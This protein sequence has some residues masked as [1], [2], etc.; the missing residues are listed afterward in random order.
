MS[1]PVFHV[2]VRQ[3]PNAARAFNLSR[4]ELEERFAQPWR[5]GRS[6]ELDDRRWNP[7]KAR[8]AVYEGRP[9][10]PEEIGMGRGWA[11]A[12]R[13]GRDVTEEILAEPS[14]VDRFKTE[15]P[16]RATLADLVALAAERYP[17][18]RVSERVA[19]AEEA[20]WQLLHSGQGR[21]IRGGRVL[22]RD[23]WAGVLLSWNAWTDS[24][25]WLDSTPP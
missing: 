17:G 14:A 11:N 23:E 19:L 8:L 13:T 18:S 10:A 24:D 9:L 6:V 21:L 22:D 2:Q 5:S 3:F 20:A 4:E 1:D 25:L 12:A 15:L 16:A 7:E